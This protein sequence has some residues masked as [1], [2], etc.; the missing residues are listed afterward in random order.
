MDAKRYALDRR[1]QVH[2]SFTS[3]GPLPELYDQAAPMS[4]GARAVRNRTGQAEVIVTAD[5]VSRAQS[6][7]VRRRALTV[8]AIFLAAAGVAV[9]YTSKPWTGGHLLLAPMLVVTAGELAFRAWW[10][11]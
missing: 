3:P 9:A 8:A 4:T 11:R 6:T 2:W 5:Q 7:R 10:P 1:H